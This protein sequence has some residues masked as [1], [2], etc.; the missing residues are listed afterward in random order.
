M[1]RWKGFRLHRLMSFMTYKGLY[2]LI[3]GCLCRGCVAPSFAMHFFQVHPLAILHFFHVL[4]NKLKATVLAWCTDND[5]V[6]HKYLAKMRRLT[7]DET[8]HPPTNP[9][10]F[11]YHLFLCGSPVSYREAFHCFLGDPWVKHLEGLYLC[12]YLFSE[13]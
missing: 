9:L 12:F 2:Y 8:S 13:Q 5:N 7:C 11:H 3:H 4:R 1:M 10:S 6:I